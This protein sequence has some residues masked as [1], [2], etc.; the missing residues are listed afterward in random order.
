MI[1]VINNDYYMNT[2]QSIESALSNCESEDQRNSLQSLKDDIIL[3]LNHCEENELEKRS[4]ENHYHD[5]M[6]LTEGSKCSVF[7]QDKNTDDHCTF[8]HNA[9]VYEIDGE[10]VVVMFLHPTCL[11]MLQCVKFLNNKCDLSPEKCRFS[12]G[13]ITNLK[14]I[15]EF[16]E[17]DLN[18]ISAGKACFA[19]EKSTSCWLPAD[20]LSEQNKS[21]FE[22]RFRSF[23]KTVIL[24]PNEIFFSAQMN[25]YSEC[26]TADIEPNNSMFCDSTFTKCINSFGSW[27]RFTKSLGNLKE[28][29]E[30][31]R[32][33]QRSVK[34]TRYRENK[35]WK[36]AFIKQMSIG[37]TSRAMRMLD[38]DFISSKVLCLDDNIE[39]VSVQDLL[40]EKHPASA[41][42]VDNA[43]FCEDGIELLGSFIGSVDYLR[44]RVISRVSKW[45]VMLE[46]LVEIALFDPP[47]AL[48]AYTFA[49]QHSWT[50]LVR[51][52]KCEDGWFQPLEYIFVNKFLP[53][54]TGLEYIP[55]ELRETISLPYGEGGLGL[56][57]FGKYINIQYERSCRVSAALGCYADIN[58]VKEAQSMMLREIRSE[59]I[60]SRLLKKMGYKS[61]CGLGKLSSGLIEPIVPS[62]MTSFKIASHQQNVKMKSIKEDDAFSGINRLLS[63]VGKTSSSEIFA[64]SNLSSNVPIQQQIFYLDKHINDLK[65]NASSMG[66][67]LQTSYQRNILQKNIDQLLD[68]R[69]RSIAIREKKETVRKMSEF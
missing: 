33:L 58:K 49:F 25:T 50:H 60:G 62:Q 5:N 51:T 66:K 41:G 48:S 59:G 27:E 29:L 38:P 56:D 28:L 22:V 21:L 3:L 19:L 6:V 65:R 46:R 57:I 34:L 2:L 37:K 68:R 1:S 31:A 4:L 13:Y 14:N 61:G 44:K 52:C 11:K 9:I 30:E 12:H 63:I 23:I 17:P 24:K 55:P 7:F 53:A 42:L 20:I 36:L 69:N 15:M 18:I 10:K 35:S 64:K 32:S 47:C 39:N 45:S 67:S 8:K 26:H 40:D 54:L 43:I 16:Q